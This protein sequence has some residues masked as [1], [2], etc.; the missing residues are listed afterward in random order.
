MTRPLPAALLLSGSLFT[1]AAAVPAP[2]PAPGGATPAGAPLPDRPGDLPEGALARFGGRVIRT[3]EGLPPSGLAFSA[4]GTRVAVLTSGEAQHHVLRVVEVATG[5]TVRDFSLAGRMSGSIAFSPDGKRLACILEGQPRLL[6]VATGAEVRRFPGGDPQDYRATLAFSPDGK[7]LV[8]GGLPVT[9]FDVASGKEAGRLP[10]KGQVGPDG[11]VVLCVAFSRERGT[12][13]R[14]LEVASGKELWSA[15]PFAGAWGRV[16]FSADGKRVAMAREQ[17]QE[18]GWRRY[19]VLVWDADSGRVA[20]RHRALTEN[21][22]LSHDGK[23]VVGYGPLDVERADFGLTVHDLAT[24]R[25]LRTIEGPPRMPLL[26]CSSDGRLAAGTDGHGVLSLW[27]LKAGRELFPATG[28]DAEALLLAVSP[29]G[30]RVASRASSDLRV[31]EART[32][33]ELHRLPGAHPHGG[34]ETT[35]F[36]V[37]ESVAFSADGKAVATGGGDFVCVYDLATGKARWTVELP[38]PPRPPADKG[39]RPR[40]APPPSSAVERVWFSPDGKLLLSAS[41]HGRTAWEAATGAPVRPAPP[42]PPPDDRSPRGRLWKGAEGGKVG[43]AQLEAGEGL[44][45]HTPD[46]RAFVT[47]RADHTLRVWDAEAS[48]ELARLPGHGERVVALAFSPEGRL[49]V[50]SGRDLRLLVWDLSAALPRRP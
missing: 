13:V 37:V 36:N 43:A 7:S 30:Q 31:W 12:D 28:H 27:D 49:L 17:D 41:V 50:T 46:G 32:G 21:W 15:G 3:P 1:L 2:P 8:R 20:G 47:E 26:A 16:A 25:A 4:D 44:L 29:D 42:V 11:R 24:G 39:D 35:A 45:G 38:A 34:G 5:K 10:A 18:R 40:H 33:R 22:A 48:R 14:A 9:V 23:A 6:D 19:E